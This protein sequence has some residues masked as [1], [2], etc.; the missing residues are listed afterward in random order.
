MFTRTEVASL[1][2]TEKI[3]KLRLKIVPVSPPYQHISLLIRVR[4]TS[5]IRSP[6]KVYKKIRRWLEQGEPRR[7]W[8]QKLWVKYKLWVN[9]RRLTGG[10]CYRDQLSPSGR[11]APRHERRGPSPGCCPRSGAPSLSHIM[12]RYIYIFFV[13]DASLPFK[14]LHLSCFMIF[15]TP[16]RHKGP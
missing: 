1:A 8:F 6:S 14:S 3:A 16:L 13:L 9:N 7:G 11:R 10:T 12:T 2:V 5:Y 4:G 15:F